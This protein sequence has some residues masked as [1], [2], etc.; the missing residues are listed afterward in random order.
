MKS[1]YLYIG[2]NVFLISKLKE[3]FK[4]IDMVVD[5]YP[6]SAIKYLN[7][8]VSVQV[9]IFESSEEKDKALEFV[10]F[11]RENVN[12][13]ILFFVIADAKQHISKRKAE[14][15]SF[16]KRGTDDI[17]YINVD[18]HIIKKDI[19]NI[20]KRIDFLVAYKRNFSSL[21]QQ[22]QEGFKIPLWKRAFDIAFS[23]VAIIC[24]SPVFFLIALAIR[25]ESKGK[26]Y[27][28]SKRVGTGYR[29]FNFYKFRSM[30]VDADKKVDVLMPQ[31]QYAK[32]NPSLINNNNNNGDTLLV[33]EGNMVFEQDYLDKK[34][35]KQEASFFKLSNDPR[36]T[37]VGRFIRNTS[38]DELLQLFN[39]LKG[40]MSVVGNRPLPLYEAEVLTTDRWIK[41]FLAPAG[42]TGLWQVTKRTELSEM[43]SNERKQLDVEYSRSYSFT[44]DLKI[45]LR[46]VP[47]LFQHENV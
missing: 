12:R 21:V 44:G 31:N 37:R 6:L 16:L 5:K 15:N 35:K 33:G 24:L 38:L 14:S 3:A 17:F 27:Y 32:D 2:N 34:Q 25:T 36:I 22:K 42:L 23:L 18:S 39:I 46:T 29:I 10:K 9:V 4:N 19:L 11:F 30:Y 28:T 7:K 13:E 41:R 1:R 40:E 20:N 47:A 45:I 8:N 26:V 43:S